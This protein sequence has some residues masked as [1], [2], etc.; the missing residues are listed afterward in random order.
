MTSQSR[1]QTLTS[2][3]LSAIFGERSISTRLANIKDLW[4]PSGECFF[5]EPTG[6]FKTHK[7]ISGMVNEIQGL[8]GPDDGFVE[9]SK[10]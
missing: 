7:E 1:A 8:G 6:V 9:M 10:Y 2:L 3:N 5:V 4:V